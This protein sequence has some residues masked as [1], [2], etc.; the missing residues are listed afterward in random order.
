MSASIALE[1]RSPVA[2]ATGGS[3]AAGLWTSGGAGGRAFRRLVGLLDD[4]MFL[5]LAVVLLPVVILLVGIPIALVIGVVLEMWHGVFLGL[6]TKVLPVI[7]VA[8]GALFLAR[9]LARR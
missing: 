8:G 4:A 9:H 7:V 3:R 6:L 2:P 5:L 1:S